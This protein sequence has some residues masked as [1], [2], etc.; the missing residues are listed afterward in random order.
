[1]KAIIYQYSE[2]IKLQNMRRKKRSDVTANHNSSK[3]VKSFEMKDEQI[4]CIKN[5]NRGRGNMIFNAVS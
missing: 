5:F 1:M 4:F 2:Y 3:Y